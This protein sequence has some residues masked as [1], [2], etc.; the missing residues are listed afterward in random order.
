MG[1]KTW[2]EKERERE[3]GENDLCA[4]WRIFFI[5]KSTTITSPIWDERSHLIK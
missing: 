1:D 5:K 2:R 4:V 3:S